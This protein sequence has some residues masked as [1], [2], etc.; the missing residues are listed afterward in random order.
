MTVSVE[1]KNTDEMDGAE[2]VQVYLSDIDSAIE[3]PSKE[4]NGIGNSIFPRV[5]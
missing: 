5:R 1:V 3:R 2:A 4:L